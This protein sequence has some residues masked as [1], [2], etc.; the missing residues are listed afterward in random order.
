MVLPAGV[1]TAAV[2]FGNGFDLFGAEVPATL[3][4]EAV[5]ATSGDQPA[6][7]RLVWLAT[8]Q[9]MLP[10]ER[11]LTSVTS[12]DLVELPAVDQPGWVDQFGNEYRNWH[13]K[14]TLRYVKDNVSAQ[15]VRTF[16]VLMGEQTVDLDTMFNTGVSDPVIVLRYPTRSVNGYFPDPFGNITIPTG[17]PGG[18]EGGADGQDG[19][20]VQL[21][22]SGT[23]IEWRYVGDAAWTNLA[24]LE[25]LRGPKGSD[26]ASIKGDQGLSAYQVWTAAGNTG[27]VAQFLASLKGEKGDS[28]VGAVD[29]TARGRANEAYT[30]ADGKFSKPGGGIGPSDLSQYVIDRLADVQDIQT[31]YGKQAKDVTGLN[32]NDLFEGGTYRGANLTNSPNSGSDWFFIEIVNHDGSYLLQRATQFTGPDADLGRVWVRMKGTNAGTWFPWRLIGAK[33]DPGSQGTSGVN[34]TTT[35]VP[36]GGSITPAGAPVGLVIFLAD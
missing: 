25:A 9:A 12:D 5:F 4:V 1:Q 36:V 10:I 8:G 15:T 17:S 2:S 29:S 13:Y 21:R 20:E 6:P 31:R 16:Q 22:N 3:K 26:G 14:A 33:G 32:L 24:T 18:G 34:A 19:R 23:N 7:D 27:T 30:L 28:T 11:T 35:T